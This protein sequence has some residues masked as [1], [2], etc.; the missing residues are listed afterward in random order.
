MTPNV[1]TV[2]MGEKLDGVIRQM[3]DGQTGFIG[4]VDQSDKLIG[5]VSQEN[6]AELMMLGDNWTMSPFGSP[7]PSPGAPPSSGRRDSASTA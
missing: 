1:P 3:R 7:Q 5:Y 6:L 2:R 4:V